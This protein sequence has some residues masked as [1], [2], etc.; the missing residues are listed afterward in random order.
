MKSIVFRSIVIV[1]LVFGI[2]TTAAADST[3]LPYSSW[4]QGVWNVIV[5]G[6]TFNVIRG[7]ISVKITAN[8]HNPYD[9]PF[10]FVLMKKAP[11]WTLEPDRI[12]DIKTGV[13]NG[14]SQTFVCKH[15]ETGEYYFYLGKYSP[16]DHQMWGDID[17]E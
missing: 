15:L 13:V 6:N 17:V 10:W 4:F 11:A 16:G 14:T 7:Q 3:N 9:E 2:A 5:S 1:C 12:V 8:S